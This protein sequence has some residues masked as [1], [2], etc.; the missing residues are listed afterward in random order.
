M[1]LV[2]SI[3]YFTLS[4]VYIVDG[5]YHQFE[6]VFE[7]AFENEHKIDSEEVK[8][9]KKEQKKEQPKNRT[10]KYLKI[11]GLYIVL[12]IIIHYYGK[13]MAAKEKDH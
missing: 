6:D 9:Q 7:N 10:A 5:V 1:Q 13:K 11:I 4:Y 3:L 2:V 12:V 8:E